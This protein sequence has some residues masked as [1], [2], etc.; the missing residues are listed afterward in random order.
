MVLID[1]RKAFD[2]LCNLTLLSKLYQLGTSNKA[3]QWFHSYLMNREQCTQVGTSL[4]E[5]LMVTHGVPQS[6]IL[7][8]K[9]F[10]LNMND[11]PAGTKF[12]IRIV[13]G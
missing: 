8:P 2:S 6:S 4:S 3:L 12:S 5:P 7:S 13:R 1:L 11:L 10:S 9:P